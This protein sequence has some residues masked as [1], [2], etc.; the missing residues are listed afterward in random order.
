MLELAKMIPPDGE[1]PSLILQIQD[2]ADKAGIDWL[3]IT[4]SAALE[5]G[6][7]TYEILPLTLEFTG[8]FFDISDFIY[9]A[10]QM[11]AGPGRL[12]TV[13]SLDLRIGDVGP[14]PGVSHPELG[15]TMTMYA[16]MY[17]VALVPVTTTEEVI[18]G[19]E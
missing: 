2:L 17:D 11:V 8:T 10:E 15:V 16:F 1:L 12:L 7:D 14:T 13:K 9:R 4:P 3:R 18:P 5:G 19:R 6:A